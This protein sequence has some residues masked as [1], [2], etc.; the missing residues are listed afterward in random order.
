MT[1]LK[2]IWF[3]IIGEYDELIEFGKPS[4]WAIEEDFKG[5]FLIYTG[6]YDD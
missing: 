1:R 6:V 4:D 3:A 2:A 5:E